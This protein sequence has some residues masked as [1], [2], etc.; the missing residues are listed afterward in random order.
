MFYLFLYW[1][2]LTRRYAFRFLTRPIIDRTGR[3]LRRLRLALSG[4]GHRCLSC[5]WSCSRHYGGDLSR[6]FWLGFCGGTR[7]SS[8]DGSSFLSNASNVSL[9]QQSRHNGPHILLLVLLFYHNFNQRIFL[10]LFLT[11]LDLLTNFLCLLFQFFWCIFFICHDDIDPNRSLTSELI[12]PIMIFLTG[13]GSTFVGKL[14]TSCRIY[15]LFLQFF[16][17]FTDLF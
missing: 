10:L 9:S 5:S 12:R 11:I 2:R 1:R 17:D 4:P 14:I 3:I 16:V 13:T 6:I 8:C 15:G 7:N